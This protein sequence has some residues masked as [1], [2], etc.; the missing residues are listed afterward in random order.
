[1]YASLVDDR[2]E[3]E[4]A[5]T[6]ARLELAK[7]RRHAAASAWWTPVEPVPPHWQRASTDHLTLDDIRIARGFHKLTDPDQITG[8]VCGV[9]VSDGADSIRLLLQFSGLT[10][11]QYLGR[12]RRISTSTSATI[13]VL[14][15]RLHNDLRARRLVDPEIDPLRVVLFGAEIAKAYGVVQPFAPQTIGGHSFVAIPSPKKSN[16]VWQHDSIAMAASVALRQ[17]AGY[18]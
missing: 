15:D 13:A 11:G 1:M 6:A 5:A 7:L 9:L 18:L 14:H 4:A 10:I 3:Q 17:A 2:R 16:P 8:P 12:L